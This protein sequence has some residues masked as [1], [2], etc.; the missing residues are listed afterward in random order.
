MLGCGQHFLRL[1][2]IIPNTPCSLGWI[3]MCFTDALQG[4]YRACS[5]LGIDSNASPFLKISFETA[6]AFLTEATLRG[7]HDDLSS[8]AARLVLGRVVESG[9]GMWNNRQACAAL[10]DPISST[11]VSS[12]GH[13]PEGDDACELTFNWCV[14]VVSAWCSSCPPYQNSRSL[15]STTALMYKS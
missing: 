8:P 6:T 13:F 10:G 12:C 7:A 1:L 5:R 3:I 11:L 4:G 2:L 14:Q 9:T 15:R